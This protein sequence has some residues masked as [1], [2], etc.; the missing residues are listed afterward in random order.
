MFCPTCGRENS[1]ERKFCSSCGTNLEAVTQALSGNADDL[2]TR[3]DAALDQ[4]IARYAEHVFKNAPLNALDR[5]VSNSWKVL[6]QA[7]IT[8]FVDLFLFILMWNIIPLKFLIMLVSSPI[9]LL[10]ERNT[11]QKSATSD[12]KD[13]RELGPPASIHDGWSADSPV[14]VTEHTTENLSDY[15]RTRQNKAGDTD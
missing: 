7:V 9:K 2:F 13:K 15:K 12:L 10:S 4:F 6:G 8:S 5:K 11:R 3:T 1:R 14:T